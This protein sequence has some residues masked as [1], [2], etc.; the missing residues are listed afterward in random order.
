M[1]ATDLLGRI[2]ETGGLR[3]AQ[4]WNAPARLIALLGATMV[5]WLVVANP[6]YG[7][8]STPIAAVGVQIDQYDA[9]LRTIARDSHDPRL[10]DDALRD[11]AAA[12]EPI[13][14]ALDAIVADLSARTAAIDAR[15]A[16][17]GPAP[18][19][20][21][22]PE[23]REISQQRDHLVAI[24]Q[25]IDTEA[26]QARVLTVV[27][28]Q[29][30]TRLADR[31]R[32]LF[33]ARL[34][35]RSRSV[36]DP[37]L[38]IDF[39]QNVPLDVAR[40][41]NLYQAQ[42]RQ[43]VST[44]PSNAVL[45]GWLVSVVI[46][47]LLLFPGGPLLLGLGERYAADIEAASRLRRSLRALWIVCVIAALPLAAGWLIRVTLGAGGVLTPQM[48]GG[49]AI[50]IRATGFAA[51]VYGIGRALLAVGKPN[52]RLAPISDDLVAK[53]RRYPALIAIAVGI[54]SAV[55]GLNSTFG[56]SLST[57]I[58]TDALM[59]LVEL[60]L[61]G[62]VL[63]VVASNRDAANV[64]PSDSVTRRSQVPWALAALV[65]WLGLIWAVGAAV[66][67]YLALATFLVREMIWSATVLACLFLLIQFA[68]DM[69]P[70]LLGQNSRTGR[71]IGSV[72][73]LS[74]STLDQIGILLA[75][76]ARLTL[77]L[78][79][80]TAIV[81]PLGASTSDVFGQIS[82]SDLILHLGPVAI[83]PG[84][85]IGGI[86]LFLLG[87][88]ITR[89]IRGWVEGQY[90]PSTTLDIGIRTSLSA[91]V[92]YLGVIVAV[93]LASAYLGVSLDRI[94]LLAG[95]LSVG[96]GFGLQAVIGNF[97]SGLILLA[98]RPIKVG[99]WIAIG[100][101]EG[102]VKKI[103]V[104]ATEIEM[105]DRSRLIVPNSEL[106]TK[107]VRNVT[108]GEALGRIRIVLKVNDNADVIALRDLLMVHLS[109]H[110]TVLQEPAPQVFLTD[111]QD[112]GLEFTCFAY[113]PSARQAYGVRS[114]LYFEIIPDLRAKGFALSNSAPIVNVGLSDRP[115]EPSTSG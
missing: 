81:A 6:A 95:A 2:E 67:G 91:G 83:S 32:E 23:A 53:L 97:V 110:V 80:W 43:L 17:L 103:N 41:G 29:L 20:G 105:S 57:S 75:G 88:L 26:R 79:G 114:D 30:T 48:D 25:S 44:A 54:A 16:E 99:D 74:R 37:R 15:L 14:Q 12:I 8:S 59:V 64:E 96:I 21:Q 77:L 115:I 24:R 28:D 68:D 46:A 55:A 73:G 18:G 22:P 52:W 45:A 86:L 33:S 98:E 90:L 40:L 76:F 109:G 65:S 78:F 58:I 113:V 34:W 106:V 87:L 5:L 101:L 1:M 62:R 11:K 39:V 42:I 7:Q 50:L 27:T 19:A 38:W 84:T 112:G 72:L 35:T 102:D 9:A 56:M 111:A 51:L 92:S 107:T 85:I 93:L 61:I 49:L 94:V 71:F 89:A 69:F 63:T 36:L 66:L 13:D 47:G 100:D 104:R 82:S 10:D 31:R 4:W 70:A 60:A 3:S 108:H